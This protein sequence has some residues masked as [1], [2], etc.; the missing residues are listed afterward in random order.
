MSTIIDTLITDRTQSDVDRWN[1]LRLKDYL[2]EMTSAEQ[3]EWTSDS[4]GSYN[5]SDLNRVG[6]AITYLR[7]RLLENSYF[8][9]SLSLKTNWVNSDIPSQSQLT[10]YL[11]CVSAIR[12][13]FHV[14]SDTPSVPNDMDKLNFS[15]AND[16][17][18]IL[19]LIEN[20]I[21]NMLSEYKY[22]GTFFCNQNLG[23]TMT[24]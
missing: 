7:N 9:P 10:Y 18:E 19:I 17:E 2:T 13:S 24:L 14:T 1:I 3:T 21:I 22:L 11:Y 16:I 15:E 8:V 23:V 5:I 4:K 6:T 20:L 12:N